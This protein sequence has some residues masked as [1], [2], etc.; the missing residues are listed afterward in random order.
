MY[1]PPPIQIG[2]SLV[3]RDI[4]YGIVILWNDDTKRIEAHVHTDQRKIDITFPAGKTWTTIA[5]I[6]HML[7]IPDTD[8]AE[9]NNAT[10]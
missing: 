5:E 2:T 6:K 7:N 3:V 9:G 1:E 10:S 8:T 4:D